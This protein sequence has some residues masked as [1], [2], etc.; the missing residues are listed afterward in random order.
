MQTKILLVTPPIHDFTAYDYWLKPYGLLRVAG[1]LRQRAD[2]HLF[3]YLDRLHPAM[4]ADSPPLRTDRWGRGAFRA[5]ELPT[6]A[7]LDRIPRIYRR[8][9]LPRHLFRKFL[10]Q[11]APFDAV[12]IQTVMTY[13]YPGVREVIADIR[14]VDPR[15][16]IV[17]GGVYA[18]L[19][20]EHARSLG[21]DLVVE[22]L[23]LRPLWNFLEVP[24]AASPPDRLPFWDGYPRLETGVV[25]LTE[26]CPFRCTYCSVPQV[27]SR[28]AGDLERGLAEYDH[29]CR[30]GVRHVAFYDDAL[31][32]RAEQLFL[33]FLNAVAERRTGV[34]LHT[35]NA[36]NARFI[37]P[38]VADLMVRAGFRTFYLGFE[39]RV[40]R[41]Q[42]Q[43]GGK[44]YPAEL[45][46]G[47]R[48]LLDA[49]AD[50]GEITAYLLLG[51]PHAA[52]QDVETSMHF[53]HS[54]GI[55][56]MLSEFSPIPGTPDGE[57]CRQW[58]DMD[59]PLWHSKTAF[60]LVF[61]G[62]DKVKRLKD[63]GLQ[64]NRSLFKPPA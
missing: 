46:S 40:D 10:R 12:L 7:P 63:L 33:P 35:P 52:S 21:P 37:S 61:L 27:Y 41:W 57:S 29:L 17:L 50:P 60:P 36:L 1:H 4:T 53:A 55:R 32:F 54:L 16:R 22:G 14:D 39:S 59:E 26:G 11:R 15:A 9:G 48:H 5:A 24:D 47:V 25:K 45:E 58:V 38:Q 51:H 49:G 43:T 23:D 13:W 64:F 20:P 56:V 34:F 28:F 42:K 8:F 18:T 62:A 31:L 2:L 3:D 44:V 19:C 30:L 6:P